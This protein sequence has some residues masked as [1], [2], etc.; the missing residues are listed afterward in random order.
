MFDWFDSHDFANGLVTEFIAMTVEILII[1]KILEWRRRREDDRK[2]H[3]YRFSTRQMLGRVVKDLQI[4]L[5]RAQHFIHTYS[6]SLKGK[7]H[8]GKLPMPEQPNPFFLIKD[9][10]YRLTQ[11]FADRYMLL[12]KSTAAVMQGLLQA[13]ENLLGVW[14]V[15]RLTDPRLS[16]YWPPE[17]NDFIRSLLRTQELLKN[18][19]QLLQSLE[20]SL[21]FAEHHDDKRGDIELLEEAQ[22]MTRIFE[23]KHSA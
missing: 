12:D 21:L 6:S 15:K 19:R 22:R 10:H 7:N 3:G 23:T 5:E 13:I 14:A 16:E 20:G 9:V 4:L 17:M 1:V 18:T 2:L 11:D 8:M